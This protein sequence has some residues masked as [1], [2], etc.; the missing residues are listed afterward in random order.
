MP[1][2][3]ADQGLQISERGVT[4]F[5]SGG[6]TGH[7]V[8]IVER[9]GGSG[10][11]LQSR[12]AQAGF[13]VTTESDSSRTLSAIERDRPDLVML[14]W[15][16]PGVTAIDLIARIRHAPGGA[17]PRLILLS[18]HAGEQQVCTGFDSGAD[19]Y[20]V[21][22]YSV[23]EVVA[24][25]RAVLRS[26]RRERDDAHVLRFQ[27]LQIKSSEVRAMARGHAVSLRSTEYRLLEF[28]MRNPERAFTRSQ[29]LDRVWGRNC[30]AEE[31]AVDVTIQRLR[32]ALARFECHDYVQTVR[33]VGYRISATI[34]PRS[35][36]IRQT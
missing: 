12:L 15:D 23:A 4:E 20:V 27:E 22:P 28:L 16:Q 3:E 21:K 35:D 17:A 18:M 5:Y 26:C 8:L 9:D 11:A 33:G 36:S 10:G 29:L 30:A 25:V 14:D 7:R 34:D 1:S 31:R 19:D 2:S 32:K 13:G 6:A 24:R